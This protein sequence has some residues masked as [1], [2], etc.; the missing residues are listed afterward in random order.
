[1]GWGEVLVSGFGSGGGGGSRDVG[2]VKKKERRFEMVKLMGFL[3]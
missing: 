1:M 3:M 2:M